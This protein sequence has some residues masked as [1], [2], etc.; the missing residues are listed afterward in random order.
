MATQIK[1]CGL[2]DAESVD[3]ALEAGVDLLGFVFFPS[4]P[5]NLSV[6]SAAPLMRRARGKAELVALVVDPEQSLLDDVAGYLAPDLIQLHG[7]ET[8][9]R[10]A[11]I[12][13]DT[14][15]PVMKA[16]GLA[17]PADLA[18]AATYGE[19][20]DRLLLDA[21]PPR[22]AT[23]PGGNGAAFD[24]SILSSFAPSAPWLLSG[25]LTPENVGE[26][27]AVAGAPGV[28]VSSG[29]ERAPGEKDPA[30]IH[31]FVTAVRAAYA[32]RQRRA[33]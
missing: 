5:R 31:A 20:A 17:E 22:D 28:D 11:Q 16:V 6:E 18:L 23:R 30:L 12:R 10:V 15:I 32:P 27:L 2:R 26:A 25:G 21:K 3:A 14:G 4:S 13:A 8:P 24:W 1:I 7:R 9:A 29:V 33:G 19:V